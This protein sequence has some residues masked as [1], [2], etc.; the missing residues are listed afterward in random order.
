[1]IGRLA[2]MMFLPIR[3]RVWRSGG[4]YLRNRGCVEDLGSQRCQAAG[5]DP[6]V[7][8]GVHPGRGLPSRQG[9]GVNK[10]WFHVWSLD[11]YRPSGF[12]FGMGLGGGRSTPLSFRIV[13]AASSSPATGM[14]EPKRACQAL[15]IIWKSDVF[16]ISAHPLFFNPTVKKRGGLQTNVAVEQV[17]AALEA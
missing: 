12:G 2:S 15:A 17:A 13:Q 16:S 7:V 8:G 1:M 14:G 10:T 4:H 6:E 5:G 11:F 3:P 9:S